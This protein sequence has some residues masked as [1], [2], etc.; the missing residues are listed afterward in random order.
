M[1]MRINL[2]QNGIIHYMVNGGFRC[3]SCLLLISRDFVFGTLNFTSHLFDQVYKACRSAS[4][5]SCACWRLSTVKNRQVSSANKRICVKRTTSVMSFMNIKKRSGPRID[6]C[7]R[8]VAL[9][10]PMPRREGL[11]G[12]PVLSLWIA[13]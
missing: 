9:L 13:G 2:F 10:I 3:L 7:T 1:F 5:N 6:P 12:R 11:D 8:S 4:I